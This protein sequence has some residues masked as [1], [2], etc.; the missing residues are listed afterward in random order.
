[1]S[2]PAPPTPQEAEK[3]DRL[4]GG[5]SAVPAFYAHQARCEK[6]KAQ[7]KAA[8]GFLTTILLA[9]LALHAVDALIDYART[10]YR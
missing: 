4:F 10:F 2:H 5:S 3:L 7:A 1:M 9:F 8:A 6:R